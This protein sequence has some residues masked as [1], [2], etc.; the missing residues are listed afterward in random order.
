[1]GW[2]YTHREPGM[3]DR[4][5]FRHE[6]GSRIRILDSATV[7]ST[8]YAA[9]EHE[10]EPGKVWAAVVLVKRCH[11]YHNFGW[12]DMG[13]EMGPCESK[14]PERILNRLTETESPFALQWRERCRE[15]A[16]NK[17]FLRRL[18][19][20]QTVKLLNP[21]TFGT[22]AAQYLTKASLPRRKNI[23]MTER[24][25]YVRFSNLADY[26]FEQA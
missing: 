10:N 16:R 22:E 5:W 26:P 9:C 11:G 3:A 7:N 17:K 1:M 21:M 2:S 20:G 6:W 19:V 8:F 18:K 24:G 4:A 13:E 12:K 15:Y 14:C 25:N 23:Y